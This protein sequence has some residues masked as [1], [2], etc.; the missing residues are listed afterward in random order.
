M[1]CY[2]YPPWPISS[3]LRTASAKTESVIERSMGENKS[4]RPYQSF[5]WA[6][7]S[8]LNGTKGFCH[9]WVLCARFV[10]HRMYRTITEHVMGSMFGTDMISCMYMWLL[11]QYTTSQWLDSELHSQ[12]LKEKKSSIP[13]ILLY[14]I[15]FINYPVCV[16]SDSIVF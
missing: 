3:L 7:R 11:S 16:D 10:T 14:H 6:S 4:L 15:W 5:Q 13:N 1:A 12:P 2:L 9:T 8:R